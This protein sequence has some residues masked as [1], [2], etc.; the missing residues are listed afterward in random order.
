[1][2]R[3]SGLPWVLAL[4]EVLILPLVLA[5]ILLLPG[6]GN[7]RL[8]EPEVKTKVEVVNLTSYP[9]LPDIQMPLEPALIP[10]EYEVPRD[11]SRF[12]PKNDECRKTPETARDDSWDKECGSHPVIHDSNVLYGFDQ[13]NW[14]IMLSNLGKLREY[15][16]LLK[17][18]IELANESRREWRARAEK[19]RSKAASAGA[20]TPAAPGAP[21]A[22]AAAAAAAR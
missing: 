9:E 19:E 7:M 8:T 3:A 14:N 10:W 17:A 12:E 22:S 5:L 18:R 16:N 2:L 13:R 4:P 1:V 21:P 11:M 15:V 20:G 6:C